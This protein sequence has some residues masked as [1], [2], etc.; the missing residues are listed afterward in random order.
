M[1]RAIGWIKADPIGSEFADVI[2]STDRLSAVGVAIGSDPVPYRLDYELETIAG[3]ITSRLQVWSRGQGWSRRLDLR[4]EPSGEWVLAV[5]TDGT[6]GLPASGGDVAGLTGV[7]DCDLGLSPLTNTMPVL[8]HGL[9]S[10][11]GPLN[12]TM[13]WV[14]V[15][16]LSVRGS[17]QRYT[18]VRLEGAHSIVRYESRDSQF[19]ADLTVDADGIVL[20]Y[21]GIGRALGS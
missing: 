20:D 12:F 18:F 11:G 19:S 9:L 13:A 5:E 1:N 4:R 17:L 16:D 6:V 21:P 15:P 3:F 7:L 8:R 10:G 14:S 2:L